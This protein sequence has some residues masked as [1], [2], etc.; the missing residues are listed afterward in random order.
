MDQPREHSDSGLTR[1]N[2]GGDRPVDTLFERVYDELK[3]MAHHIRGSQVGDTL[4]TT[5]LVH[6]AYLKLASA[7][8]LAVKSREHFF[9][10]AARA[11]RQI[12]VDAARRQVAKKRGGDVQ[13]VTLDESAY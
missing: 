11:M 9:A 8:S 12:L 10:V 13:W 6:E 5:A 7:G 4:R 2:G 3:R 1:S